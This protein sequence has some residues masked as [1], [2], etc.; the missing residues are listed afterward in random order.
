MCAQQQP[1]L[2]LLVDYATVRRKTKTKQNTHGC[3]SILVKNIP[4]EFKGITEIICRWEKVSPEKGSAFWPMGGRARTEPGLPSL[5]LFSFHYPTSVD[6]HGGFFLPL[7]GLIF[8]SKPKRSQIN[9]GNPNSLPK[10]VC[11]PLA[12]LD[13][14]LL[15]LSFSTSRM[16]ACQLPLILNKSV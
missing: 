3:D 1:G 14:S 8:L 16:K 13:G 5:A 7:A 2:V 6:N 11:C 12:M 9:P 4:V 10:A 15:Q